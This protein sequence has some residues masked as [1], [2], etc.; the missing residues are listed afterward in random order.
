MVNA[1]REI[2]RSRAY[3]KRSDRIREEFLE[4]GKS[5]QSEIIRSRALLAEAKWLR[6]FGYNSAARRF[7]AKLDEGSTKTP[8]K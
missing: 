6:F 4:A 2:D 7:F 3:R 8:K 1:D 5:L